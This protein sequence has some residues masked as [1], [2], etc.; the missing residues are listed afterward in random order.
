MMHDLRLAVLVGFATM[1]SR[2]AGCGGDGLTAI[3]GTITYDGQPVQR[4][5]ILFR[6][7]RGD[8]PTAAAIVE[9]GKFIVRVAPGAKHVA[10]EGF[11]TIGRR[12]YD[13]RNPASPMIDVV[14]Q[15]LPA[16]YNAKSELTCEIVPGAPTCDFALTK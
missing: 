13:P 12:H 11:R 3:S 8:G 5:K 6:A 10:I 9:D 2:L 1:L 4:G 16:R 7:S 15:I 14:E